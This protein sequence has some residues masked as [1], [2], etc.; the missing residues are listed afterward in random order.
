MTPTIRFQR[1]T[2][3]AQAL[4]HSYQNASIWNYAIDPSKLTVHR[5]NESGLANPIFAP[6]IAPLWMSANACEI[7]WGLY[8]GVPDAPPTGEARKCVGEVV[9]VRLE[10]LGGAKVHLVDLPVLKLG[11]GGTGDGGKANGG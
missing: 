6:G 5:S 1:A 4:D 3:P 7:E 9:D 8:K 11:E 2:A 10:P